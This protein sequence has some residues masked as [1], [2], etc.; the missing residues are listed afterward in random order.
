MY[1]MHNLAL[2]IIGEPFEGYY[3]V[4]LDE[5]GIKKTIIVRLDLPTGNRPGRGGRPQLKNTKNPRKKPRAPLV[6]GLLWFD[7]NEVLRLIDEHRLQEVT[8]APDSKLLRRAIDNAE[9]DKR[10]QRRLKVMS[11][12]LDYDILSE[13]ILQND[14]L[15]GLVKDAVEA[16][17]AS[18]FLIYHC[19]SL[20]CRFGFS[21]INLHTRFDRCGAP[22]VSRPCEPNG[23][24]KAGAKTQKQRIARESGADLEPEQP[25]MSTDW[26]ARILAADQTIPRPKP[27]MRSRITLILNKAFANRI[28]FDADGKIVSLPLEKGSYPNRAQ[29]K[30]VLT[31]EGSKLTR[32]RDRTTSQH[33]KRS[34]RG[35]HGRSWKGV[36]GPGHTWAIDSTIGD[37]YLR[38]S[39]NRAWIVGRPILYII[40]DVWSTAVVGFYVCLTGPSWPM[41][42]I[43]LFSASINPTLIGSLWGYEPILS[44]EPNPTLC[45]TLL[46]DRGEYLSKAASIS[47]AKLE[48]N[49]DYTPPYRPDLKGLVEVL[50]RIAKDEQFT[51]VPGA[52]DH[53]RKE[54]DLKRYRPEQSVFTVAEYM[55]YLHFVFAEYNLTANR[56]KRLDSHMHAA[57]VTGTPAGLWHWG[58]EVGIG[59]NRAVPASE[60]ITTLLPNATAKVRRDGIFLGDTQYDSDT[61][62]EQEWAANA[63]NF[64]VEEFPA[65]YFPGSVSRIW[66]PR[67]V[68]QGLHE[69]TLVDQ[70][71]A[72][73]ELTWDEVADAKAYS[74]I[75]QADKEHST[76]LE[77]LAS[78]KLREAL[79]ASAKNKTAEAD[80]TNDEPRPTTTEARAAEAAA[81]SHRSDSKTDD[82]TAQSASPDHDD[83][84]LDVMRKLLEMNE[85]AA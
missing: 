37:L 7:R 18:K 27:A 40:A 5:P 58:H 31:N 62:R 11:D 68:D 23:R 57:A 76:T 78:L 24:K 52:I 63:R 81:Q 71:N 61:A 19:F 79:V 8:I 32:K 38:S 60:L 48:L 73:Q 67:G 65:L 14:N 42:Q 13:S 46:C 30:R 53:R 64:G 54:F 25:G 12:F 1:L 44:L 47:G 2:Q 85:N 9:T 3:R 82:L 84:Y 56:E 22:G 28:E 33:F 36:N 17:G 72:S 80:S 43:A 70:S 51:F 69:L 15:G 66:T 41:A 39:L 29:V 26:R 16:H 6:G 83:E 75:Q 4:I 50:H 55:Q 49:L 77:A 20:L 21:K 74:L 35:I 10:Y 34:Q 45:N 59:Y